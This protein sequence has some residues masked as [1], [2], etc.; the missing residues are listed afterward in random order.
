M[1]S[2]SSLQQSDM[3]RNFHFMFIVDV[4]V[5]L[6]TEK[7]KGTSY[8]QQFWYSSS[9]TELTLMPTS[10]SFLSPRKRDNLYVCLYW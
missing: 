4:A 2:R 7:L 10:F 6:A 5:S 1:V 8:E 9:R 3:P